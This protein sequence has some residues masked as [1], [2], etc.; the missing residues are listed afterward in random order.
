MSWRTGTIELEVR[1][2]DVLTGTTEAVVASKR[3]ETCGTLISVTA[4]IDTQWMLR[5]GAPYVASFQAQMVESLLRASA[6]H[7][8]EKH[9]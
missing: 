7:E 8:K 9:P 4:V 1:P 5:D 2:P 3:C 6:D